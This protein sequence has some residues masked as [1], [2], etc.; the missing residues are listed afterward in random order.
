MNIIRFCI[1]VFTRIL[2]GPFAAPEPYS[3]DE[4]KRMMNELRECNHPGKDM[5]KWK[6]DDK[7]LQ[8]EFNKELLILEGEWN[9][10][11]KRMTD[12]ER[13]VTTFERQ[14]PE[15]MKKNKKAYYQDNKR[16]LELILVLTE[17]GQ[18]V[19]QGVFVE[20]K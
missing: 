17:I 14:S 1:K 10:I 20:E 6:E 13:K 7:E 16:I 5:K 15:E 12:F 9:D 3:D 4:M 2:F 18:G 19:R 8:K 11:K